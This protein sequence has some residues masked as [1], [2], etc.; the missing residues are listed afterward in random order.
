MFSGNKKQKKKCL[1]LK[2][3]EQIK[4]NFFIFFVAIS[5]GTFFSFFLFFCVCDVASWLKA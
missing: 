4:F 3:N 5:F 1:C 2:Y